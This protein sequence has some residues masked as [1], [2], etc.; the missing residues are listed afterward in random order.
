MSFFNNIIQQFQRNALARVAPTIHEQLTRMEPVH[1]ERAGISLELL[2]KGPSAYPWREQ[3]IEA[4][5]PVVTSISEP[6][7]KMKIRRA[8]A[9]LDGYSDAELADLG[10]A[11]G[12]I[13]HVVRFGRPGVDTPVSQNTEQNIEQ[14]IEQNTDDTREA[15]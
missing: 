1:L 4:P 14:N 13:H 9:E 12:D 8:I 3:S 10:I 11:R 2:A 7:E 5:Q 15:A 6:S